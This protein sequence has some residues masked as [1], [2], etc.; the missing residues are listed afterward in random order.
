MPVTLT[1][2]RGVVLVNS[3]PLWGTGGDVNVW[4]TSVTE[5]M[6]LWAEKFC[7][8]NR[9]AGREQYALLRKTQSTGILLASIRGETRRIGNRQ[10]SGVV[11]AGA[12]HAK[13]V[14]E[15]TVNQGRSG[16]IYTTEGFARKAEVDHFVENRF[17]EFGKGEKGL[18]MWLPPAPGLF[19]TTNRRADPGTQ[20]RNNLA[21]RVR[22]QKANPFL[23]DAY[24]RT[25]REHPSLPSKRFK[26][27]LL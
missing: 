18:V 13:Y 1:M 27:T 5:Q 22:G 8:P 21:M 26:R 23:T 6:L 11:A 25:A 7:P 9:S 19:L 4:A 3:D 24:V 16:Y 12:P 15:G 14:L 2:Q 10:I 20:H 17:F